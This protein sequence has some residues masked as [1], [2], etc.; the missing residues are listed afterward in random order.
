MASWLA[1]TRALR[2]SISLAKVPRASQFGRTWRFVSSTPT[3]FD[4]EQTPTDSKADQGG[5]I[6]DPEKDGSLQEVL[7]IPVHKPLIPG[8]SRLSVKSTPH[9]LPG[10]A[11]G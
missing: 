11:Y 3:L 5:A 1:C 9:S 6:V 8:V 10:D 2:H 7:A 4:D